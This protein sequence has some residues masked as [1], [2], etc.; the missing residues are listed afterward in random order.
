MDGDPQ[1][2]YVH[3]GFTL[4]EMAIVLSIIAVLIGGIMVGQSMIRSS[5]LQTVVTDVST[6]LHAI[7]SFRDKYMAYPGDFS[8]AEAL[9]GSDV[10]C[11][12]TPSNTVPKIATCNGN[13]DGYIHDEKSIP[14]TKDIYEEFRAWQQLSNAGLIKGS[15]TGVSGPA[16]ILNYIPSVN[17]PA[18]SIPQATYLICG[19]SRL[20]GDPVMYTTVANSINFFQQSADGTTILPILSG[21]EALNI[22][23]KMDDGR[24]GTGNIMTWKPPGL[25]CADSTDPATAKYIN[26]N[27]IRCAL[28][29]F[30]SP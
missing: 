21:I 4:V 13:G 14:W 17:S 10:S 19:N 26:D 18:S 11:P 20:P 1:P 9:W 27:T 5:Q 16:G 28:K 3:S 2:P 23:T 8:N 7:Q 25:N 15:Y 30:V 22:D 29:F 6:Y 24:P 12:N